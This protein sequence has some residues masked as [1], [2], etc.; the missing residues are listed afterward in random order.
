MKYYTLTILLIT[1]F[2]LISCSS[3][4]QRGTLRDIDTISSS[5]KPGIVYIKPKTTEEIKTA[6]MAYLNHAN[7]NNKSRM[8]AI[9]RLAEIEFNLSD[10]LLEGK[11]SGQGDSLFDDKQYNARLD[12]TINLLSTALKDYPNEKTNDKILYQLSKAYEQRGFNTKSIEILNL[13]AKK[14]P[15][16]K[17]YVEAQFRIA[18]AAFSRKD[19]I[20]A[21]DAYTEV[22]SSKKN[23]IYFEKSTFKRAWARYKQSYY[24]ESVD[25]IIS[26][27]KYHNFAAY[28]LLDKSE[29]SIFDEY[30][31]TLGLA[32]AYAGG[33]KSLRDYV[34][35]NNVSKLKYRIYLSVSN[36]YKKQERYS[37]AVA[38][39]NDF[40]RQESKSS[41][42]PFAHIE[43]ISIW[44]KGGFAEKANIAI[45]QFYISYNPKSTFWAK[46]K[47]DK[48]SQNIINSSLKKN[49]L[50]MASHFHQLYLTN[51]TTLNFTISKTWY[52]RFLKH[53][54]S[55]SQK[56]NV[57]FLYAELLATANKSS[58]A[59]K[60][61]ELAAFD[62][63]I[64]LDKNAAYASILITKKLI[65]KY[66]KNTKKKNIN[67]KKHIE[68]STRFTQ[69][70]P[71]DKKSN[72]ILLHA[73]EISFANKKY[74]QAINLTKALPQSSSKYSLMQANLI[75]AQSYYKLKEYKQSEDAYT[76]M[77][78]DSR[79]AKNKK[80]IQENIA[81]AI[82][83]QGEQLKSRNKM[84]MAAENFR[85]ISTTVPKSKIAA[86][87]LYDAIA[88]YMQQQQWGKAILSIQKFKEFYPRHKYFNETSK[89]L[90][91]AYLNSNQNLKAAQEFENLS[92]I[93]TNTE[94]KRSALLQAAK[95]YEE[96]NDTSSAIRAYSR[97]IKQYKKPYAQYIESMSKL[98]K[99]HLNV[100]QVKK[101]RYWE[102]K[103][104]Q[105]DSRISRKHKTKRTQYIV[106]TT[107][108]SGAKEK[109]NKYLNIR[110]IRPLKNNLRKKKNAMQSSVKLYSRATVYKLSEPSSEATYSIAAIYYDF[111]KALLS[112]EL[113]RGLS[114]DEQEQYKILLE[115]KAFPFEEKAIEFHEINM[116]HTKYDLYNDWVKKSHAKLKELFPVRYDRN[117]K[118]DEYANALH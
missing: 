93:D 45:K 96:K 19:Y 84:S 51:K 109:E 92:T 100:A 61:Y 59:L 39:L 40:I 7:S 22:I 95:L 83:K 4:K 13:L 15:K 102:S 48:K 23:E 58:A 49:I 6:Y 114:S 56:D 73:A 108:L 1:S 18:E 53:Y 36:I 104:I 9:S 42:T 11:K 105:A 65:K 14:Y 32:F 30:Y 112:S 116:E 12:K 74:R 5:Q 77:L 63:N 81:L 71:N 57:N 8:T 33:I 79:N 3:T 86:T 107:L 70:Y 88:I 50:K 117:F 69:L 26:T 106:S 28:E 43:I 25:D 80:N 101:S 98:S 21:E 64:I 87:G 75:A 91:I 111:S 47:L 38:V 103:I 66:T 10:K 44:D 52:S 55:S 34:K 76:T 60:H 78:S 110:L 115:D 82:Y 24:I 94:V 90:S 118:I 113:P 35:S 27:I 62:N 37:D 54:K 41:K 31:R 2:L 20:T 89:K 72:K 97:Y 29:K 16:S 46:Q 67:L 99:L 68:Y 85:R 17:Y